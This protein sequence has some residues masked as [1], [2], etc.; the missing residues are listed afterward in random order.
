MRRST[1]AAALFVVTSAA[2]ARPDPEATANFLAGIRS[3][4]VIMHRIRPHKSGAAAQTNV[5]PGRAVTRRPPSRRRRCDPSTAYALGRVE[6][7]SDHREPGRGDEEGK[8]E[9]VSL[10]RPAEPE[11]ERGNCTSP[12]IYG[13]ATGSCSPRHRNVALVLSALFIATL[14]VARP[15]IEINSR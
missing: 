9:S 1:F 13:V 14:Q 6:E 3:I 2:H 5:Q 15:N 7:R 12:I 10:R 11:T 8:R 4:N